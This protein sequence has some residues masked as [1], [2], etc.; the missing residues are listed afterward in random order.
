MPISL[1]EPCGRTGECL[2]GACHDGVCSLSGTDEPCAYASE[3]EPELSCLSGVCAPRQEGPDISAQCGSDRDCIDEQMCL[4]ADLW[5]GC[6]E[7]VRL[8][9]GCNV[10]Q[11]CPAGLV[12]N[13]NTNGTGTCSVPGDVCDPE[14]CIAGTYCDAWDFEAMKKGTCKAQGPFVGCDPTP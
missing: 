4:S 7:P 6:G 11:G 5:S 9:S 8:G 3:C 2:T 12:C 13:K 1:G 10:Y 14:S